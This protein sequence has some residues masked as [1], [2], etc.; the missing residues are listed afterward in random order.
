ME[1]Q[2][3]QLQRRLVRSKIA[4]FAI[5]GF[6]VLITYL[7]ITLSQQL[8]SRT[9]TFTF[10]PRAA[11]NSLTENR[12]Q[13]GATCNPV[14]G[15]SPRCR[16]G[17]E[18]VPREPGTAQY[19]CSTV[20]PE[21]EV[22]QDGPCGKQCIKFK[23]SSLC[24]KNSC[25]Q[26]CSSNADCDTGLTCGTPGPGI[27]SNICYDADKP[28]DNNCLRICKAS[29]PTPTPKQIH[30]LTSPTSAPITNYPNP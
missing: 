14:P 1:E 20:C 24:E 17:F 30:N 7:V 25:Y 2:I 5:V 15:A 13:C 9:Q 27:Y 8:N 6:L 28:G 18:C 3:S 12:L 11:E 22:L 4:I 19:W 16:I 21:G 10:T 23:A 29:G 26:S